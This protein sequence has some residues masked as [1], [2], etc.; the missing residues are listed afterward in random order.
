MI[1]N[2]HVY[3]FAVL[4]HNVIYTCNNIVRWY[5]AIY[6]Y[7]KS[8]DLWM[9]QRW[10]LA[11]SSSFSNSYKFTDTISFSKLWH[12]IKPCNK[13]TCT[14]VELIQLIKLQ[15]GCLIT[16]LRRSIRVWKE[17][18]YVFSP[19]TISEFFHTCNC[20]IDSWWVQPQ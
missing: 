19:G 3:D 8:L 5:I 12:A 4:M 15:R 16:K 18:R 6:I 1:S 2:M 17:V 10:S 11:L 20:Y 13:Q 14:T 9:C 7:T